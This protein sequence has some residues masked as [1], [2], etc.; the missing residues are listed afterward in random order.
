MDAGH[1]ADEAEGDALDEDHALGDGEYFELVFAVS[2]ADGR[3][4]GESQPVSGVQLTVIGEFVETGLWLESA[5][6]ALPDLSGSPS[7]KK[8][9]ARLT[10]LSRP[11]P[12]CGLTIR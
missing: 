12:V 10:S 8:M 5:G 9:M 11:S 6:A 1:E 2:P 7:M 3:R 4:L